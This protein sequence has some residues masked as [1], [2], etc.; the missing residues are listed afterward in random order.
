MVF[1]LGVSQVGEELC[2]HLGAVPFNSCLENWLSIGGN[3]SSSRVDKK[4]GVL[5]QVSSLKANYEQRYEYL[6]NIALEVEHMGAIVLNGGLSHSSSDGGLKLSF[7][8]QFVLASLSISV[9]QL[10]GGVQLLRIVV[11]QERE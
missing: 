1:S 8:S 3:S 10:G 9:R 11:S 7:E 2:S 5:E 4:S 6:E